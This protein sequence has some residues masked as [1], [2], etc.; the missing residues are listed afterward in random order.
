MDKIDE[1]K[2]LSSQ[3]GMA[4]I[5]ASVI[6]DD[7]ELIESKKIP[8]QAEKDENKFQFK[9][10]VSVLKVEKRLKSVI[11]LCEGKVGRVIEVID[12]DTVLVDFWD[13]K[14][15]KIPVKSKHLQLK[16]TREQVEQEAGVFVEASKKLVNETVNKI[17]AENG[18]FPSKEQYPLKFDSGK[19]R[20]DL[21][22]PEFTMGLGEAL[23]YGANKYAEEVGQLPNYLK[24]EGLHYSKIIGSLERHINYWKMGVDI[25]EESG[26]HHL[27]LAAA[28]LMFL[29]TYEECDM[30]K[31]DRVKLGSKG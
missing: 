9:Y 17:Y 12:K 13:T 3:Q 2:E 16:R 1:K 14:P 29:L 28:N 26:L 11:G 7:L 30:G 8:T 4:E 22:R 5:S 18:V 27:K 24:G 20:L 10:E 25:D 6:F 31:D 19:P 21:V 15:A 23:A